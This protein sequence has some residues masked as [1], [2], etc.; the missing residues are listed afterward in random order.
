MSTLLSGWG[1]T[2]DFSDAETLGL[3]GFKVEFTRYDGS[4]VSDTSAYNVV[5]TKKSENSKGE[6]ILSA[7]YDNLYA[8]SEEFL[9]SD[10]SYESG[11]G[12]SVL[13]A[14]AEI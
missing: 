6:I 2:S 7:Q 4:A 5:F 3:Q 10:G 1:Y 8:D 13:L 12:T 14:L 9:K 11:S